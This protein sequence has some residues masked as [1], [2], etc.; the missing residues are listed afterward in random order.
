M[1]APIKLKADIMWAYLDTPNEMSGKYQV[2]L[3]NL[4]AKAVDALEGMGIEVRNKDDRG[5]YITCKSKNPIRAYDDTGLEMTGVIVGNGSKSIAVV[6]SYDWTWKNK[7][8]TSPSL[9]KLVVTDLVSYEEPDTVSVDD[10][11]EIL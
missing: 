4:S 11:D 5:Y 10:D 1:T 7:E 9:K 2:D 8:G 3:C 6:G